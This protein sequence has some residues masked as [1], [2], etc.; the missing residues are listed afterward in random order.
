MT[1]RIVLYQVALDG[2][3]RMSIPFTGKHFFLFE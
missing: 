3:R 1:R 2:T